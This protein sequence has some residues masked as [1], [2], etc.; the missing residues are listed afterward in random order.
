VSPK[1]PIWRPSSCSWR[2][3]YCCSSWVFLCASARLATG[4]R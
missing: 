1:P 3:V 4:S 2:A